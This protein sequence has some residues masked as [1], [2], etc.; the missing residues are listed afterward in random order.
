MK[1]SQIGTYK[2][3]G[4]N[5]FLIV[6]LN[7][8]YGIEMNDIVEPAF[9]KIKANNNQHINKIILP[10]TIDSIEDFR[11]Y[12]NIVLSIRNKGKDFFYSI[13]L[14]V[15]DLLKLIDISIALN[16]DEITICLIEE[17]LKYLLTKENCLM[18]LLK[19]TKLQS[20]QQFSSI[21]R[22]IN[23][24]VNIL[25]KNL[26]EIIVLSSRGHTRDDYDKDELMSLP[27]YI[28][29]NILS[30]Y[31]KE[32][33]HH[34]YDHTNIIH[35]LIRKRKIQTNDVFTLLDQE[36]THSI[37]AF[38]KAVN[39][40]NL[41]QYSCIEWTLNNCCFKDDFYKESKVYYYD[42]YI[43]KLYC[44]YDYQKDEYSVALQLEN[45][46]NNP[47]KEENIC[48]LTNSHFNTID[49]I[50]ANNTNINYIDS[51]SNVKK[52]ILRLNNV[53]LRLK[54]NISRITLNVNLSIDFILPTIIQHISQKFYMYHMLPSINKL[55]RKLLWLILKSKCIYLR[56]EDEV[57]TGILN[58][59]KNK[60]SHKE[61]SLL[62]L[63]SIVKW[64]EISIDSLIELITSY[65][66]LLIALPQLESLIKDEIHRR[67]KEEYT[68]PENTV[69][70][71]NEF[72][73]KLINQSLKNAQCFQQIHPIKKNLNSNTSVFHTEDNTILISRNNIS[74]N[75]YMNSCSHIDEVQSNS[76]IM[77]TNSSLIRQIQNNESVNQSLK[78]SKP[79][80]FVKTD[81]SLLNA[82]T[83]SNES[84]KALHSKNKS[85]SL[86]LN[87]LTNSSCWGNTSISKRNEATQLKSQL[88]IIEKKINKSKH[89]KHLRHN[90]SSKYTSMT[91]KSPKA[92]LKITQF[93]PSSQT[94]SK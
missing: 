7:K 13:L 52:L 41:L 56:S 17:K 86:E 68:N 32:H 94:F 91:F 74:T 16:D 76:V 60:A 20:L 81:I 9:N 78:R 73:D 8:E 80:T 59:M 72:I 10:Q 6:I 51:A 89:N 48:V 63:F 44:Y 43:I 15:L 93:N 65:S 45:N 50:N 5:K 24:C 23:Y 46:N 21:Q 83:E 26:N 30:H 25:A 11:K 87:L 62:S 1:K 47:L 19:F 77:K 54:D 92:H 33:T 82:K 69:S 75:D 39:D 31:F 29:I 40:N 66:K 84:K 79:T 12:L 61:E 42:S 2:E 88:D 3:K 58:W 67:L 35:L 71:T 85:L 64:K 55:S 36:K 14:D 37:N 53:T 34:G 38:E 27:D 57:L 49:D 70:F 22:L 4:I 18:I 90:T 28:F